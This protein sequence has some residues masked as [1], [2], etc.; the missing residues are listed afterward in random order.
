[1]SASDHVAGNREQEGEHEPPCRALLR[2]RVTCPKCRKSLSR[3]TLIYKHAATCRSLAD[4]RAAYDAQLMPQ[5][6][7]P[8]NQDALWRSAILGGYHTRPVF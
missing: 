4:R 1:M 6:R 3:K 8:P 2:E 7:T 5:E